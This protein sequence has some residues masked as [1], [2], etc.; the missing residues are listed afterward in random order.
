MDYYIF[1]TNRNGTL[2]WV[3]FLKWQGR[4]FVTFYTQRETN[5][6]ATFT[7]LVNMDLLPLP[8]NPDKFIPFG[9]IWI[10]NFQ[11]MG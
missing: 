5:S 10:A 7:S 9:F 8:V 4:Q 11:I 1:T 2:A 3:D 6:F